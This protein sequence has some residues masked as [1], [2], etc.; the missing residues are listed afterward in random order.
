MTTCTETKSTPPPGVAFNFPERIAE[1]AL[2]ESCNREDD[3]RAPHPFDAEQE[4][5][6][7]GFV[8]QY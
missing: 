1:G 8:T 4:T 2:R 7:Q 5:K 6:S 3:Y